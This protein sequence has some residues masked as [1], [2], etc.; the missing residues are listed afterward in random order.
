M[1]EPTVGLDPQRPP[2]EGPAAS[3]G[4]GRHD[5][6]SIDALAGRRRGAGRPHR[7]RRPRPADRLRH[8]GDAAQAGGAR[9]LARRSVPETDRGGSQVRSGGYRTYRSVRRSHDRQG[10]MHLARACRY[11]ASNPGSFSG[12]ACGRRCN[13]TSQLFG[14]HAARA[15]DRRSCWSACSSGR[16]SSVS[17]ARTV[18]GTQPATAFRS[19]AS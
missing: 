10:R 16:L 19:P 18:S 11:T 12:C 1:D 7:H 17:A 2:A 4:Q 13:T 14:Q 6:V 15:A 5:G 3:T 9:R 8:A